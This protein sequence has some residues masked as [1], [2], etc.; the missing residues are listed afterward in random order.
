MTAVM[1]M[2]ATGSASASNSSTS[3]SALLVDYQT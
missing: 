2:G 1:T 3:F